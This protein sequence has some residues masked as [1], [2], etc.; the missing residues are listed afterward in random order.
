MASFL[1]KLDQRQKFMTI[2]ACCAIALSMVFC[3]L[4]LVFAFNFAQNERK[5]IYVL[6]G[7]V[8]YTASQTGKNVNLDIEAKAHVTRFHELFFNLPPD[9]KYIQQS[10]EKSMYLIDETGL[11]QYNT[12]KERG[13]YNNIISASATFHIMTDSI[14]FSPET[15]K[16]V[17][18]GRQ[19]IERKSSILYRELVTEGDI[20]EVQR[21]E[22][23]PHGL[24]ITN[25]RTVLNKDLDYRSKSAF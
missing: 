8:P 1:E 4:V 3:V 17:Y 25:Y 18:Y 12:L 2:V 21:T 11:A 5:Q 15:M 13:F 16:F 9:D 6:N 7:G 23:N 22:N 19:R 24:I 20:I 14:H 10:I